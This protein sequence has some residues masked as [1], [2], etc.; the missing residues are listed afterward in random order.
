M[1]K[2]RRKSLDV[3]IEELN[4]AKFILEKIDYSEVTDLLASAK[5]AIDEVKDA[6]QDAFDNLSEGLQAGERGQRMEE[7]I[8]ELDAASGDI[9]E[10]IS[11]IEEHDLTGGF[12]EIAEKIE[13][14]KE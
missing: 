12:E 6:E 7:I 9:D 11:S 8:S 4:K 10:L 14:S 13:G 3:A 1:N 2:E 5:A